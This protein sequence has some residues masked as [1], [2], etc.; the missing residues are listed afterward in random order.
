M[1]L[2]TIETQRKETIS[3]NKPIGALMARSEPRLVYGES[4]ILAKHV[5]HC[6]ELQVPSSTV[7]DCLANS[8]MCCRDGSSVCDSCLRNYS[9]PRTMFSILPGC[10]ISEALHIP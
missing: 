1:A 5:G 4:N 2:P 8:S 9:S 6:R 3:T 7:C 10:V